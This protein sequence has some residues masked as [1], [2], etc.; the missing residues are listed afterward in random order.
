MYTVYEVCVSNPFTWMKPH[1]TSFFVITKFIR[2]SNAPH[3]TP[4]LKLTTKSKSLR[5]EVTGL[6]FWNGTYSRA[7]TG[8]FHGELWSHLIY[9]GFIH[10][11]LDSIP[12]ML[13]SRYS[14]VSS[15]VY[16]NSTSSQNSTSS[17]SQVQCGW[18]VLKGGSEIPTKRPSNPFF[19]WPLWVG[20]TILWGRWQKFRNPRLILSPWKTYFPF[21]IRWRRCPAWVYRASAPLR[22]TVTFL[23]ET[24][25]K[26]MTRRVG[27]SPA[28]RWD[29]SDH[30]FRNSPNYANLTNI[31]G[32]RM[33]PSSAMPVVCQQTWKVRVLST[34]AGHFSGSPIG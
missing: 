6:S 13:N 27:F 30:L 19:W 32:Q 26:C 20:S 18:M 4:P 17:G 8:H 5:N 11:V 10:T 33:H 29:G 16:C 22:V 28:L 23:R 31:P 9:Q 24:C 25:N 34:P 12:S 3:L 7:N 1:T 15:Q 21:G 2:N 14:E